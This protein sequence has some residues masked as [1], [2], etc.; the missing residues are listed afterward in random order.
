M[1]DEAE[2]R[3][4]REEL[5]DETSF[6]GAMDG[7]SKFVRGDAVAGIIIT[8]IN[9]VGGILI[10]VLTHGLTIG[11]AANVYTILTIG[12]GLVTQIP[13]LLVSLAAG[14]VVTKGGTEGATNEAVLAQ[15]GGY[16]KAL[17]MAAAL[18]FGIALLPGFPA[19]I[20]VVLAALMAG[21]GYA[22]YRTAA[23]A[24]ETEAERARA[25][26]AAEASE[27]GNVAQTMKL[28]DIRLDMGDALVSMVNRP[29]AGLPA[30]IKSLRK[31]FGREYGFV[32]PSVRITDDS[33]LPAN[34]YAVLLHGVEVA[35]G[36]VRPTSMMVIAGLD[37][38]KDL[39]GE[40]GKDPTFG[41]DVLWADR[42]TADTAEE[43]GLTVVDPESVITTHLTEVVK[44]H[45]PELLTYGATKELLDGLDRDYQKLA[46]DI[47]GGQPTILLQQVLQALLAERVSIRNLPAIVEAVAE[48]ARRTTDVARVT[49]HVRQRLSN[50]IC[51]A[52]TDAQ[53]FVPVI[54][55]SPAW[56]REFSEAVR[57][58]GDERTLVMSPQR[59]QEFVLEARKEIQRFAQGDEWPAIMV[60]PEVRSFVRSM[61]ERVSPATQVVSH[62]EIHRKAT[63]KTVARIGG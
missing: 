61:L 51:K 20:F 48:I 17:Y 27:D 58:N 46:A 32:L 40:R 60:S 49:N 34:T 13:A 15:L 44:E 56:E 54:A 43:R 37:Q 53:G 25:T 24:D 39:P 63:L 59:V 42:T 19:P 22:L 18:L 50:Q 4:R 30:K 41:L 52:L 21:L 1:I 47:P 26:E 36:E 5:E 38:T 9:L 7:A 14:I 10:G 45:M 8:L 29:E 33:S 57:Q 31:L 11:E 12:D 3:R 35:R 55:L 16:P 23:A 6:Y 62:N 28:D 2:A